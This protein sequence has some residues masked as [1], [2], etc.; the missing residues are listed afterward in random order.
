MLWDR[1][2]AGS[3]GNRPDNPCSRRGKHG[4]G[5][6]LRPSIGHDGIAVEHNDQISTRSC[7]SLIGGSCI[8]ARS[9]VSM[10]LNPWRASGDFLQIGSRR[11]IRTVIN[12][13]ELLLLSAS[14]ALN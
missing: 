5:H 10:K 1:L 4:I 12:N 9:F 8:T 11:K 7:E 6:L 2:M 13:N 14:C 3:V